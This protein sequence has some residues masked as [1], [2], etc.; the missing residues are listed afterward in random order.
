MESTKGQ[1]AE[2]LK[3]EQELREEME[4]KLE[5]VAEKN[6]KCNP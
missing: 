2:S 1:T 5:Q 4:S 6:L 3:E